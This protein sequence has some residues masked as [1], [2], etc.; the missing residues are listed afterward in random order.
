M[1]STRSS[2][3]A[4]LTISIVSRRCY[5]SQSSFPRGIFLHPMLLF[6]YSGSTCLFIARTMWST[7]AAGASSAMRFYRLLPS[8][9]RVFLLLGSA[10]AQSRGSMTSSFV[11]LPSTSFAMSLTSA[12]ERNARGSWRAKSVTL[13]TVNVTSKVAG[14]LAMAG[15][16]ATVTVAALKH[17]APATS[18]LVGIASPPPRRVSL[19]A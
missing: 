9:L 13:A 18:T 4:L 5:A 2:S 17:V 16:L 6:R 1:A 14:L 11:W 8:T 7:S 3:Q 10:M 15:L 19:T 12:T